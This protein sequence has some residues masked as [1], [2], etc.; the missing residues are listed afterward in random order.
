MGKQVKRPQASGTATS[1]V[2]RAAPAAPTPA[3]L[4]DRAASTSCSSCPLAQQHP[5]QH[6]DL[7]AH[8]ECRQK[9]LFP[10]R[11]EIPP[12]P[13]LNPKRQTPALPALW[14]RGRGGER[15]EFPH[16]CGEPGAA[17]T[18]WSGCGG[19]GFR[20]KQ[21]GG[22]DLANVPQKK[23]CILVCSHCCIVCG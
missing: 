8:K 7:W 23:G 11:K 19:L 10:S 21:R 2:R 6:G 13:P 17:S 12:P 1:L 3:V 14:A 18:R 22:S 16:G 5:E 20:A 4:T 9:H 15:D